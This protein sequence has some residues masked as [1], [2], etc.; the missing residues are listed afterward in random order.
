MDRDGRAATRSIGQMSAPVWWAPRPG[1]ARITRGKVVPFV[2]S[3]CRSAVLEIA[4]TFDRLC[5]AWIQA[6]AKIRIFQW[7]HDRGACALAGLAL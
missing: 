4:P 3:S 2:P 6:G 7:H 1:C 5:I